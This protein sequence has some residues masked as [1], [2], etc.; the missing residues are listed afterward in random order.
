[1]KAIDSLRIDRRRL[2]IQPLLHEI[3]QIVG[4]HLS[5]EDRRNNAMREIHNEL[6]DKF[7]EQGVEIVTDYIRSDLGLP[8]RNSEGWTNE[9]LVLL[10]QRRL[11]LMRAPIIMPY[12]VTNGER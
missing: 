2:R 1:M 8:P 12:P 7:H 3:L 6:F 4:K 9:E 11:D 5:D 10:E